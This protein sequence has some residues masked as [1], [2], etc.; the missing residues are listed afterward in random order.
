MAPGRNPCGMECLWCTLALVAEGFPVI[1]RAS[2]HG[3][4]DSFPGGYADR[5]G[6]PGS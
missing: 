1:T 3:T 6:Y 5:R 4:P 2:D